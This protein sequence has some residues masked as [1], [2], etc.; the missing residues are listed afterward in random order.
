ME[1]TKEFISQHK[2]WFILAIIVIITDTIFLFTGFG[3]VKNIVVTSVISGGIVVAAYIEE[4]SGKKTIAAIAITVIVTLGPSLLEKEEKK[5]YETTKVAQPIIQES[6][7]PAITHDASFY[8]DDALLSLDSLLMATVD[9]KQPKYRLPLYTG[10][11]KEYYRRDAARADNVRGARV[12]GKNNDWI[13]IRQQFKIKGEDTYIYGWVDE[14]AFEKDD[15]IDVIDIV[16]NKQTY[17]TKESVIA[18]EGE[19]EK[20]YTI[21]QINKDEFVTVLAQV[22]NDKTG[23][24]YLYCEFGMEDGQLARGFIPKGSVRRTEGKE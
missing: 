14:S 18:R 7:T 21:R 4:K 11:G 5:P 12:Y 9:L 20:A 15:L 23:E 2:W 3:G 16:F 1:K 10:T 24:E 22:T 17:V 6:P 8:T 13:F 19:G